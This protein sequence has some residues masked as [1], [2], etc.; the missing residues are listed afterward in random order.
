M[1]TFL[2][3]SGKLEVSLNA[4]FH[5]LRL[6]LAPAEMLLC[7]LSLALLFSKMVIFQ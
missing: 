3:L 4:Y 6:F 1:S 2:S 7:F 5:I